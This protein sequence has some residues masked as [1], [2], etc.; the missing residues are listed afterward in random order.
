MT[1][2]ED[3]EDNRRQSPRKGFLQIMGG[4]LLG[5]I[6]TLF[7]L[8]VL[9]RLYNPEQFGSYSLFL[10]LA[11]LLGP[12]AVLGMDKAVVKPVELEGVKPL[13]AIGIAGLTLFGL[14]VG[15]FIM[16]FPTKAGNF[17]EADPF[18]A[19]LLPLMIWV[20]GVSL[21]LTQLVV[22]TG[23]Y[24]F[25]GMRNSLQSISITV[26]QILLSLVPLAFWLNGLITGTV[27]GTIAGIGLLL[28]ATNQYL[29]RV[30]LGDAFR[31][32]KREWRFPLVFAPTTT[33]SQL[34]MQTPL[35]FVAYQFGV[36]ESGQLGMSERIIAVPAAL[37][38][39]AVGSVFVGELSKAIRTNAGDPQK[40]YAKASQLLFGIAALVV[41]GLGTL[42]PFVVPFF[43]GAEWERAGI[44][45]QIMALA[46]GTRLI[47]MPI[48][49][50][51]RVLG[52]A[53]TIA[54]LEVGRFSLLVV[55][56]I[57]TIQLDLSLFVCL[58][59]LYG[60]Q[61]LFDL[62]IWFVGL[63]TVKKH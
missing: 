22:R 31:T 61:A 54:L 16:V 60:A 12:L 30:S 20:Q 58:G 49:E 36:A 56:V 29:G 55:M 35:L 25:I 59:L 28:S 4:S 15:I 2:P 52:R 45:V 6:V 27:L 7:A 47:V 23:R 46:A 21:L 48:H 40:I 42:S 3:S 38:G 24:G 50:V 19:T 63:R 33:L 8:P 41:T 37:I 9:S 43:L 34:S 11:A 18:V 17:P 26:F 1:S 53:R 51:F 14:A 62:L 44:M 32:L 5:Q 13:A 57:F 10:S 39:L